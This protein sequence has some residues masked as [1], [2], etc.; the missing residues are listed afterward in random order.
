MR[1][2][3]VEELGGPEVLRVADV[4]E[5]DPGQS[6][7]LMRVT[8][9]GVN[10]ADVHVREGSYFTKPRLPLTPGFEVAGVT[11]MA[12]HGLR[13]GQRVVALLSGGG[14]AERVAAPRAATFPIADGI[15]DGQALALVLQG[16]TA[17]HLCRT[18]A[19]V[20]RGESV[21]VHA[22]GGG[23]GSLAV[24]L[25]RSVGAGRVIGTA[26]SEDRRGLALALGCD[27]VV[28][29][30]VDDLAGALEAANDGDK[31]DVVLESVG[32][33]VFDQSLAALAPFGR[34]VTYGIT[35]RAQN[36]VASG[37]LMSGS[38]A[39][40]GFWLGHC[41]GREEMTAEPL[42]DL[43]ERTLRGELRPVVGATYPMSEAHRAHE[44]LAARRSSG[45]LLLDPSA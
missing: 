15:E 12:A 26:S 3:L 22:A 32:S 24:Q 38:R 23:V 19:R 34:L 41:L 18:A 30:A 36:Q 10:F 1:A 37:A 28:D 6:D 33:R 31:V 43:F 44:D 7:V 39:V 16:L 14:Y 35:S 8:R 9:A 4:P 5:P 21:V 20:A 25:A 40:V 45:K 2:I 42:R 17:W 29:P 11:H 27:A 13:A